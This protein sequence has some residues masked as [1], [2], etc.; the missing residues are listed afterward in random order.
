MYVLLDKVTQRTKLQGRR[1]CSLCNEEENASF[2]TVKALAMQIAFLVPLQ[3]RFSCELRNISR[4][5]RALV[6]SCS[7]PAEILSRHL[8]KLEIEGPVEVSEPKQHL[9]GDPGV[10]P[11]L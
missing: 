10:G 11:A 3:L 1:F 4:S 7:V 6:R 8:V 9:R 2:C 5:L